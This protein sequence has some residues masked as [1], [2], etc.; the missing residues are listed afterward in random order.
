MTK[1]RYAVSLLTVVIGTVLGLQSFEGRG[2]T[3]SKGNSKAYTERV[4]GNQVVTV[5]YGHTR[6][7]VMGMTYTEAQCDLLLMKD[8]VQ[9]YAPLVRKYVKVPLSQGEFNA[10][11][12]FVYNVGEGN[13]AASTL[14]KLINA[15]QYDLAALEFRKWSFVNGKDCNIKANKCGGIP[16]RRQWEYELFV[17]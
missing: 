14:L 3:D 5:C 11:V 17:S 16:K 15:G 13:F 7:A 9:V 10:L 6:T 2:P 1:T 4:A 8:L 12:D